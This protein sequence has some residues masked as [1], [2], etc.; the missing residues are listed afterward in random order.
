MA[1][2][3]LAS[4]N[5]VRGVKRE[6]NEA[7]DTARDLLLASIGAVSISRKQG[8]GFVENLLEQGQELRGRALKLAEGKVADVRE[9]VVG[10]FGKVQQRAAANLSQVETVVGGQVTRVLGRLGV[11]SKADVKELSR[12]VAE[13]NKQVKALQASRKTVV[14]KAA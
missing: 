4:K 5:A 10:A 7:R 2:K 13:L 14:S 1:T 8:V 9:Q 11:P 3:K 12:R 6:K